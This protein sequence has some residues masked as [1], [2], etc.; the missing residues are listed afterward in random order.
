MD[1]IITQVSREDEQL[2][3]FANEKGKLAVEIIKFSSKYLMLEEL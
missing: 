3:A 1:S 2:N